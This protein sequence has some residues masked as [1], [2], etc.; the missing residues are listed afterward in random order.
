MLVLMAGCSH[1]PYLQKEVSPEQ[2]NK[3][4]EHA[5]QQVNKPYVWGEQD[6]N[7]GFDCSGLVIWAYKQVIHN[8]MFLYKGKPAK[9]ID[10]FTLYTENS[11]L[12]EKDEIVEGDIVYI[13]NKENKVEHCGLVIKVDEDSVQIIHASGS[14][15]KV[16]IEK[17]GLK[18]EIR[19]G[20]IHSF[21]RLKYVSLSP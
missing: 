5:L 1:I 9:D 11:R 15:G 3:A 16:V 14:L 2:A 4:L 17:W 21:G 18:E 19:E 13:A 10:V 20:H 7:I 8:I 12:L 6:P